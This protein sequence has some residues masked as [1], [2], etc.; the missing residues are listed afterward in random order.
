SDLGP[1]LLEHGRAEQSWGLP[2]LDDEV[3]AACVESPKQGA[4]ICSRIDAGG[5]DGLRTHDAPE[6]IEPAGD[7]LHVAF[8]QACVSGTKSRPEDRVVFGDACEDGM[9]AGATAVA[10]IGTQSGAFLCAEQRHRGRIDVHGYGVE[11]GADQRTQSLV[12]NE[13]FES[14]ERVL[15]EAAEV[16]ID[17]VD[18]GDGSACQAL[19]Q[20]V[21]RQR[22]QVEDALGSRHG[23]V[24][25]QSELCVHGVDH[26][27]AALETPKPPAQL[28]AEPVL[29][30]ECVE[31]NQSADPGKGRVVWASAQTA[32]VQPPHPLLLSLP[33]VATSP[34]ASE[35]ISSHL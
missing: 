6:T 21:W 18:A 33:L 29:L 12:G 9:V 4:A 30:Q 35:P 34:L 31:G 28:L 16:P 13:I 2:C 27:R 8:A 11:L 17:G 22:F 32:S 23:S 10:R 25:Q 24:D 5:N 15:V 20:R 3:D 7:V 19:E 14:I 26:P 1:D